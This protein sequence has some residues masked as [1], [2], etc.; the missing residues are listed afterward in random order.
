MKAKTPVLE[1]D[2]FALEL[3]PETHQRS[4]DVDFD[5]EGIIF[6]G[7]LVMSA[8]APA[9]MRVENRLSPFGV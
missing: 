9:L 2:R 7:K 8:S 6:Q 1:E 3:P 5:L 4:L